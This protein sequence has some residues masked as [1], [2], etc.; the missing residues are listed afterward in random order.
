LRLAKKLKQGKITKEEY[1]F[2]LNEIEK[3]LIFHE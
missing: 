2:R 3:G 1:E